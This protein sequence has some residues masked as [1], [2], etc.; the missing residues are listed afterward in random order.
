MKSNLT[1]IKCPVAQAAEKYGDQPALVERNRTITYSDYHALVGQLAASLSASGVGRGDRL[2]L[3][4]DKSIEYAATIM[5]ALRLGVTACPVSTRLPAGARDEQIEQI[6][7][8]HVVIDAEGQP[9]PPDTATVAID[10]KDLYSLTE[11]ADLQAPT[12]RLDQ[13]ATI[14]FTSG[15]SGRPGAV[16]HTLGN[17][18]FNALGANENIPFGPN[19]RWLLSLPLY[20]VGGLAILFRAALGGG[21]VA[22]PHPDTDLKDNIFDLGITHLS[23]VPTQLFRLLQNVKDRSRLSSQL[24]AILL[25]GGPLPD[26]LIQ[27]ALG[28][29]WPII[30]TYGLTEMASQVTTARPGDGTLRPFNSGRLLKYRELTISGEDEILVRGETLFAGYVDGAQVSL[31]VD[32]DGWFA[33]GDCG[34]FDPEQKLIVTGRKD[35]M[36]ISG[37]EN[38]HPEEIED[39][40]CNL[41]DVIDAVV[42]AVDSEEYGARPVAFVLTQ[43]GGE[44]DIEKI[45][46]GL[47]ET[48]PRYKLPN[49]IFPWPEDDNHGSLKTARARFK[50]LAVQM[51]GEP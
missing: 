28:Y 42:V 4:L 1:E 23:L 35:N 32:D 49:H 19:D 12:L 29:D 44:I 16:L 21:T 47:A 7:A 15:S 13:P 37:G 38:I 24:K 18:Y 30:P 3:V 27:K 11:K 41:P 51:M 8:S 2:A 48:L 9:E 17:H 14:I 10:A 34:Y 22:L 26:R 45:L 39:A 50:E 20:H 5:A 46:S 43:S 33:T 6:N 36:F 25:G 40:L 31:P